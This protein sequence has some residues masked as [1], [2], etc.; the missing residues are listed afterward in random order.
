MGYGKLLEALNMPKVVINKLLNSDSEENIAIDVNRIA[1]S[2]ALIDTL[3]NS[4]LN[5]I[6]HHQKLQLLESSWRGLKA[7]TFSSA[8]I[9]NIKIR[10]LNI[11]WSELSRDLSRAIEF[12][13]SQL[14]HKIYNQEFDMPG[15]TPYGVILADFEIHLARQKGSKYNDLSTIEELSHIAA[16]AFCPIICAAS[17]SL[18]GI[19]SFSELSSPINFYEVVR[20]KEFI[21]WRK[22]R[23]QE[24]VRFVALT[25]PRFII[26]KPYTNEFTQLGNIKFKESLQDT[27]DYLWA[28][29]CYAVGTVLIR[30][31]ASVNWF[32]HIEGSPRDQVAGGIIDCFNCG[33][34]LTDSPNI[35][36]KILTE[37]LVTDAKEK[38]LSQLGFISLCHCYDSDLMAIHS[39]SSIQ[40]SK[41]FTNEQTNENARLSAMLQHI[42][43]ASRF[44]HYIKVI[45]RDKIGSFVNARR[46]EEDLQKW[47]N[48]YASGRDDL[49]WE[50]QA[51]Y[52]L[53]EAKV[54]VSETV[55]SAGKFSCDIF[56][57]PHYTASHLVA[58]LKL[59]TELV[60]TNVIN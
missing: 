48:E 58:E 7:L 45:I 15:G 42:L 40:N 35:N 6:I 24:D 11:K 23:D 31:Y 5:V 8:G 34:F 14:F 44:A 57:K 26:R 54:R 12:D 13:Q 37:V 21:E 29:G 51:R 3:I 1:R 16:A 50:L 55:A 47:L 9:K 41:N 22:L 43:C 46:C 17:P 52:P 30:E 20:Q 32:S 53:R 18:L 25:L 59:N 33:D 19:N 39:Y 2:I 27:S 10:V 4:Q 38:E 60:K 28:N 56:L 36:N 49:S